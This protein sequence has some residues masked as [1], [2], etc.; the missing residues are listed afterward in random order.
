MKTDNSNFLEDDTSDEYIQKL[1]FNYN[2]DAAENEEDSLKGGKIKDMN[3][4]QMYNNLVYY[5]KDSPFLI[6]KRKPFIV[7]PDDLLK[8][9]WEYFIKFVIFASY[10]MIPLDLAFENLRNNQAFYSSLLL[11]N[12]ICCIDI[13]IQFISAY[14][15]RKYQ[16]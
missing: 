14:E 7:Y 13:I 2:S 4:Q 6:N 5:G 12:L 8:I 10:F 15:D 9:Y 16:I 11:L 3:I 1:K